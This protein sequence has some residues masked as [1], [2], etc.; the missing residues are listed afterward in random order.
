LGRTVE[1]A[2][3][4]HVPAHY[5]HY[6]WEWLVPPACRSP[7]LCRR[8]DESAATGVANIESASGQSFSSLFANFGLS[9]VTDSLPG[10][11]P[12]TAPAA[13][14]FVTRNIRQ[15]WARLFATASS[16][17]FPR[18]FPILINPVTADTTSQT[19]VPDTSAYFRLNSQ[20]AQPA[21]SLRFSAAGNVALSRGLKPQLAIFRL[22]PGQ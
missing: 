20:P 17:A 11:P 6:T 3:R 9:L 19:M 13:D 18:A 8:L 4:V 22:P 7:S 16:A 5:S 10:L 1:A 2:G 15:L 12:T 21:V 14:R